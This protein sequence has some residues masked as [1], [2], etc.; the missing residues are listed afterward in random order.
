MVSENFRHE[1]VLDYDLLLLSYLLKVFKSSYR[2]FLL[3]VWDGTKFIYDTLQYCK[4]Y[5]EGS[6]KIFPRNIFHYGL[7]FGQRQSKILK[8]IFDLILLSMFVSGKKR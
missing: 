7:K 5:Y 2:S 3:K 6:S 8:Q 1:W 4:I